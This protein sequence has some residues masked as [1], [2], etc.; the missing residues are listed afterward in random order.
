MSSEIPSALHRLLVAPRNEGAYLPARTGPRG[1]LSYFH[2]LDYNLAGPAHWKVTDD[3]VA[4]V[5]IARLERGGGFLGDLLVRRDA[6]GIAH[7]R[8]REVTPGRVWLYEMQVN[9]G[10]V[11]V[12]CGQ[13]TSKR[14]K[15]AP[16]P[17][18]GEEDVGEFSNNKSAG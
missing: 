7:R 11:F 9:V 18:G 14:R 17:L 13:G 4:R 12:R 10:G 6:G 16:P 8:I 15:T 5:G 1:C 3:V 2:R